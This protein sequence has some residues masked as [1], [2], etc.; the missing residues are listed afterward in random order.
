MGMFVAKASEV[1]STWRIVDAT[2]HVL[3]RLATRIAMVLMGKHQPTYT[4]HVDTGDHVIVVNA[5]K[6]RV[7][8][9]TKPRKRIIRHHTGFLG[10]GMKEA[11]LPDLFAKNP[12]KVVMLAVRR[13]LPKTKM[14]R[15]FNGALCIQTADAKDE[16]ENAERSFQNDIVIDDHFFLFCSRFNQDV[17]Q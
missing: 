5:E 12:E 15:R 11:A 1:E 2:D 17:F 7:E 14:G 10:V 4:P 9:P 16:G 6:I 3:G 8:P 13:M